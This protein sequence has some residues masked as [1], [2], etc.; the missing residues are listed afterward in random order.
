MAKSYYKV[1]N[2]NKYDRGMIEIV[3][4]AAAGQEDGR[5]S[6]DGAKKLYE[7]I[8]DGNKITQIEQKSL[9]YIKENYKFTEAAEEWLTEEL[10][11]WIARKGDQQTKVKQS[12]AETVE[13][14]SV[15]TTATERTPV[16]P[17]EP[18]SKFPAIWLILVAVLV[19][20]L[21]I[22][23]FVGKSSAPVK[24]DPAA[25]AKIDALQKDLDAKAQ[26]LAKLTADKGR[27][28]T[29]LANAAAKSIPQSNLV[30][31]K[32]PLAG[33]SVARE[34][35]AAALASMI[36]NSPFR[37]QILFDPQ[38]L[39]LTIHSDESLFGRGSA[40][41][42]P[43]LAEML[44]GFF[45]LFVKTLQETNQQ[46][47]EIQFQGHSSSFWK[48]PDDEDDP[49]LENMKLSVA[50]AES[51]VKFCLDLEDM[52]QHR[53]WLTQRLVSVGFSASKP[54]IDQDNQE[55]QARSRRVSIVVAVSSTAP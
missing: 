23:Y 2:G 18:G 46:V 29:Q 15:T 20:L 53:S 35:V 3:E 51:A 54:I 33:E 13:P 30:T 49:Y 7:A 9:A 45:P 4:E 26:E 1:I 27:L 50:R 38:K 16:Q 14:L 44:S 25:M 21:P 17:V 40:E 11:S 5:I 10:A 32:S 55:D 6:I 41:L 12:P 8:I 39:E 47:S 36:G 22:A 48:S 42:G 19:V 28:K 52:T 31:E 43:G 34:K 24:N 37:K